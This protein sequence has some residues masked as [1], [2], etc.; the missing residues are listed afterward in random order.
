[1]SPVSTKARVRHDITSR[2]H[3]AGLVGEVLGQFGNVV[4]LDLPHAPN[5]QLF[6]TSQVEF[7]FVPPGKGQRQTAGA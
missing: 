2:R 6:L 1:M 4:E 3:Y 7:F 5:P